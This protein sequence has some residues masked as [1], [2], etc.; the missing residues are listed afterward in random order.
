LLHSHALTGPTLH[1]W[2]RENGL[3]E[4]QLLAW[5]QAFCTSQPSDRQDRAA[6]RELQ[7]KHDQLQR[8]MR[9]KDKALAETA[10]LL[11]LQKKF[12]ALWVDEV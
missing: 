6:L 3:F 7:T 10:A 8:D 11:V 1:A 2:C 12:Q 4:H 5:R 9:R